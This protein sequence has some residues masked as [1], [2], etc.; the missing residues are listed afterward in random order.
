MTQ[1]QQRVSRGS[2]VDAA[3]AGVDAARVAG[4]QG[5]ML[6]TEKHGQCW[7]LQRRQGCT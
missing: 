2:W 6:P 4:L 3:V 7:A 1:L 5:W